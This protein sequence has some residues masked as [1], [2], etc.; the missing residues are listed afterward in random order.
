MHI[1]PFR[2]SVKLQW[3]TLWIGI[4]APFGFWKMIERTVVMP[5]T[6]PIVIS[7]ICWL[8]LKHCIKCN[9]IVGAFYCRL[10][11][12]NLSDRCAVRSPRW[13]WRNYGCVGRGNRSYWSCTHAD[14]TVKC[15][16]SWLDSL[17]EKR[18]STRRLLL[19]FNCNDFRTLLH[20][21]R[22]HVFLLMSWV[23]VLS[24]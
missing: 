15:L 9:W 18:S 24:H 7:C 2:C 12:I 3:R 20:L 17:N 8:A 6:T 13:T 22:W 16:W 11:T 1:Y 19:I 23:V 14:M 21:S 4:L 5:M 10:L